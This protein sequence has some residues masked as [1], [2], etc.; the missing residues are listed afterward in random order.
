[1]EWD[2]LLPSRLVVEKVARRE[3][4]SPGMLNP[5]LYD[6]VDPLALD[7]LFRENRGGTPDRVCFEYCDYSVEVR[8]DGSVRVN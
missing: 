8:A 6:V 1:M 4:V 3:G 5:P 7:N 2:T